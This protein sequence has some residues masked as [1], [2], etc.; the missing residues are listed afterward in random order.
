MARRSGNSNPQRLV[1]YSPAADLDLAD[2]HTHTAKVW[3]WTQANRYLTFLLDAAQAVADGQ[4]LGKPVPHRPGNFYT[5]ATWPN[6]KAGHRI[7]Y[8][9]ISDGIFVVRVLHTAMDLPRHIDLQ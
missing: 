8:E 1:L 6:A 4:E 7:V 2:I 9:I 5:I 3:G